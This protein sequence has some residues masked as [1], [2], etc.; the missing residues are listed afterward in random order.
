VKPRTRK[1]GGSEYR[2]PDVNTPP[3]N[4][5][6]EFRIAHHSIQHISDDYTMTN[7]VSNMLSTYLLLFSLFGAMYQHTTT[8]LAA[9]SAQCV[10]DADLLR[11]NTALLAAAPTRMCPGGLSVAGSCMFDSATI[12][13]D[14]ER[15]CVEEGG[16]FYA[17][18]VTFDCKVTVSN[19]TKNYNFNYAACVGASCNASEVEN[20]FEN[21][22]FPA[23][24]QVLATQGF[25]C[26]VSASHPIGFHFFAVVVST[27]SV[28]LSFM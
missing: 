24:E 12:S 16:Q 23:L 3:Y 18:D 15:V 4:L 5:L 28:F 13:A 7:T 27:V 14:Y 22:L 2:L 25:Q 6:H 10:A 8:T 9:V 19:N 11:N 26:Q 20:S 21:E 1:H 17:Q